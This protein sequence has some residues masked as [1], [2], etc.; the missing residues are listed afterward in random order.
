MAN[1]FNPYNDTAKTDGAWTQGSLLINGRV[2]KY[3][4]KHYDEP[5]GWGIMNGRISKL[6]IRPDG[7]AATC[8]YD[9]G[10]DKQAEDKESM[11][12][13]GYLLRKYN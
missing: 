8:T 12:A 13:L 3:S 5:S 11:I 6:E 10:W 1:T 2:L 7:E 4:V 9:R